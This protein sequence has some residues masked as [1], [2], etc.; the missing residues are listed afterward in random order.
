MID[1]QGAMIVRD[2]VPDALLIF[3]Q[4][5]SFAVLEERLRSRNTDDEATIELR[6]KNARREIAMASEYDVQIVNDTSTTPS[7]S[8]P[9]LLKQHPRTPGA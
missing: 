5:P 7:P 1:V 8:W 3:V 4:A 2:K 9:T 6:L